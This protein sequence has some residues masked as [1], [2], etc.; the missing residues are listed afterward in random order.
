[1]PDADQMFGPVIHSDTL[2]HFVNPIHAVM[3][4]R[5]AMKSGADLCFAV[6]T[7]VGRLSRPRA[8]LSKC[9]PASPETEQGD[10]AV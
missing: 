8:R 6:P 2:E 5:C 10:Q 4:Y 9:Y 3:E 1:M 7:V